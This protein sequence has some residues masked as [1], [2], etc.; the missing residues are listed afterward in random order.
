MTFVNGPFKDRLS[1]NYH[2]NPK[3][4]ASYSLMKMHLP[5]YIIP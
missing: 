5:S 1:Q 4:F 2:P 3:R